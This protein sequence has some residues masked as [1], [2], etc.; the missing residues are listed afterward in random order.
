MKGPA[1]GGGGNWAGLSTGG[2][3]H[4]QGP[5]AKKC[6]RV[7]L[8]GWQLVAEQWWTKDLRVISLG[9]RVY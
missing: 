1:P 7:G 5:A 2:G 6:Q 9:W 8:K 3:Q 4:R